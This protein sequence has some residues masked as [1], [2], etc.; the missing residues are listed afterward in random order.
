MAICTF[1]FHDMLSGV[2]CRSDAL[3]LH[4]VPV[5]R[6]RYGT[7]WSGRS[8]ALCGDCGTPLGGFHHPGCDVERCPR[9]GRQAITCGHRYD[10]DPPDDDDDD[11]VWSDDDADGTDAV[12]PDQRSL[13]PSGTTF[14]TSRPTLETIAG[15]IVGRHAVE[16]AQL[17]VHDPSPV[18]NGTRATQ[19]RA[20]VLAALE[21]YRTADGSVLLRRSSVLPLV[22][23]ARF[24]LIDA[25][26]EPLGGMVDA[27]WSVARWLI[28]S[29]RLHPDSDPLDALEQPLRCHFGLGVGPDGVRP[30][31]FPCQCFFDHDPTLPAGSLMIRLPTDQNAVGTD[32][33]RA[34]P[35]AARAV[36]DRFLDRLA[37]HPRPRP[38]PRLRLVGTLPLDSGRPALWVFGPSVVA[39]SAHSLFLDAD[40]NAHM[41]RGD[42]RFRSGARWIAISPGFAVHR[43]G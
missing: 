24:T 16:L 17:I 7:E 22:H 43:I 5:A 34:D 42:R 23:R 32:P 25:V 1:C 28:D 41:P 8:P 26:D 13:F 14:Q 37:D 36:L 40:G 3:H 39:G 15:P 11:L 29:D 38:L 20:L 33:S 31:D 6:Q 19:L 2:S 10:E 21:P 27:V 12:D 30:I 9:C 18:P 4:G 35:L